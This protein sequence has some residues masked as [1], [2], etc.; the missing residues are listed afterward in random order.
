[1]AWVESVSPYF[2]ARHES[3]DAEDAQRLLGQLERVREALSELFPRAPGELTLVIHGSGFTL[4]MAQPYLVLAR[5]LTAP[6]GRR[7]LVGWFGRREL[8]V[9]APRL[10]EQRAS[11]VPGSRELL[12]LAPATLYASVLVGTNNPELPPP[13]NFASF[14]RYMRWAWLAQ[15]AA[16][17]FA[18]QVEYLRPAI[19]RRLH[20][21]PRPTFPPGVR[22]APLLGGTVLDL[23]ARE[24]GRPAAVRLASRLHPGGGE[25][26]LVK[27]FGGRDLRHTESSWRAHLVRLAGG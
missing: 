26:A 25:A 19:Q 13:F 10:L 2:C 18:G 1:M 5:S 4:H 20:E 21:G 16:Q 24:E 22:D 12:M 7:Y 11:T 3:E 15:G 17:Y 14:M 23:L 8:H 9:L 6:A 27:A